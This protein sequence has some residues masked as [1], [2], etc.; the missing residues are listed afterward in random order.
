MTI[1]PYVPLMANAVGYAAMGA[2]QQPKYRSG[3]TDVTARVGVI[4]GTPQY[5]APPMQI[6]PRAQTLAFSS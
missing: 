3:G 1:Y 4:F 6:A 2:S 5:V